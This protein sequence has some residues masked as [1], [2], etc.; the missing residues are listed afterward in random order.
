MFGIPNVLYAEQMF[1][2]V[3]FSGIQPVTSRIESR[4]TNHCVIEKSKEIIL[5]LYMKVIFEC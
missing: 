2:T 5:N 1:G 4:N 3:G